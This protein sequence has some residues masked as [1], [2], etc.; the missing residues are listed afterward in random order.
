MGDTFD[1]KA[2]ALKPE[3]L[4]RGRL[5]DTGIAA[6]KRER[7]KGDFVRLSLNQFERLAKTKNKASWKVFI[8]L[9]FLDWRYPG[10]VIQLGNIALKGLGISRNAKYRA[11]TELEEL[12]LL[13]V[14]NR[15]PRASPEVIVLR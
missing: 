8:R 14:K 15:L 4:E 5:A 10:N 11:L 1:A 9:L 6:A 3:H 7:R 2:L 13:E 12:G